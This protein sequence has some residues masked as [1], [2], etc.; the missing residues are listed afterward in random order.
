MEALAQPHKSL[1]WSAPNDFAADFVIEDPL[2]FD[3]LGQQV[4]YW[5]FGGLT[6]RTSRAQYIAVVLYGLW[7]VDEAV[8]G[9]DVDD[10]HR[11][12][13]FERWE[14][15][16]ALAIHEYRGGAFERSDDDAIRGQRGVSRAWRPSGDSLPLDYKLIGRQT[17]LGGLG[18]YMS[19]LRHEA[20]SLV[21][22]GT[23][24]P[25]A[26]AMDIIEAFWAEPGSGMKTS[27]YE[28]YAARSLDLDRKTVPRK[29]GAVT[30]ARV[31]ELSRLTSLVALKRTDQQ[32]R[33]WRAL[34]ERASDDTLRFAEL[35]R[36]ATRAGITDARLIVERGLAGDYGSWT[37]RQRD[38]LVIALAFGDVQRELMSAFN[39]AYAVAFAHGWKV[40]AAKAADEALGGAV[41]AGLRRACAVVLDAPLAAAFQR[42]PMHGKEFIDLVATLRD[43]SPVTALEAIVLY[44]AVIHRQ[45]R[46]AT[47]WF[48]LEEGRLLID[49]GAY[50]AR[51]DAEGTFPSLKLN[52][53]RSLLRDLGR[54]S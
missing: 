51:S 44:H 39:R 50:G 30:L 16:W 37:E 8:R 6:T 21:F 11:K 31:G 1:F 35:V 13:L 26:L 17:E 53:V 18:A 15:F 54:L 38:K 25:T 22:P 7:L 46:H 47:P 28:E 23:L 19:A 32:S 49:V 10:E 9:L 14:R 43:A 34:F 42:L 33:L 36:V 4:G 2:A 3:Y 40:D 12:E 52:V 27:S 20:A 48:R 45:R 29:H 5:L 24:R 41:G